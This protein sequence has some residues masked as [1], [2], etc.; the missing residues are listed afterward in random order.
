MPSAQ[1]D[2]V[3]ASWSVRTNR[4]LWRCR[5]TVTGEQPMT[6]QKAEYPLD[7]SKGSADAGKDR[8]REMAGVATEK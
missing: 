7:Y 8:L 5:V 4:E 1:A 3:V 2:V 6:Q